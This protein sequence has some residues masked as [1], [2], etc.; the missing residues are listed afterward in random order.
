MWTSIPGDS[1]V[2][3]DERIVVHAAYVSQ[4]LRDTGV[5]ASLVW[6]QLGLARTS[7]GEASRLACSGLIAPSPTAVFQE[8]E[9][10]ACG[11]PT[12]NNRIAL[13]SPVVSRL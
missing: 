12:D 9:C 2:A 4:A 8:I 10:G 3:R 1:V 6:R 13:D 5:V 7:S 11:M